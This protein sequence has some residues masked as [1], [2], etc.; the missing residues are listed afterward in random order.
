MR[1]LPFL[2]FL[3]DLF[4][5]APKGMAQHV[6]FSYQTLPK[7]TTQQATSA[8]QKSIMESTENLSIEQ[9]Y[10]MGEEGLGDSGTA[11]MESSVEGVTMTMPVPTFVNEEA[12]LTSD[13]LKEP[14]QSVEVI[15][16]SI[17]MP[18]PEQ[19][20]KMTTAELEAKT[21]AIAQVQTNVTR[22]ALAV[23]L[24]NVQISAEQAE[25]QKELEETIAKSTTLRGDIQARSKAALSVLGEV[26]RLLGI[27]SK[28]L[29]L[30]AA[31][32]LSTAQSSVAVGSSE[33][34]QSTEQQTESAS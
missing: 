26:N 13:V 4:L 23:A 6:T 19:A 32:A 27:S 21:K 5:C 18:T 34:N 3:L 22:D 31:H 29:G 1:K 14:T 7:F 11:T 12:G 15:K 24:A 2:I 33:K 17:Q 16:E 25:R 10:T 28:Y 8:I 20:E 30:E 9:L